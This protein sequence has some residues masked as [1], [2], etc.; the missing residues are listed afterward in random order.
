MTTVGLCGSVST[1]TERAS[2]MVLIPPIFTLIL[3][4]F[5]NTNT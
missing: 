5:V 1:G 3:R 4:E 2:G